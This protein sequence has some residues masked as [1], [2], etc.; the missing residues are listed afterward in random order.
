MKKVKYKFLIFILFLSPYVQAIDAV[1]KYAID[2]SVIESPNC[3]Q[4]KHIIQDDLKMD[5]K[6]KDCLCKSHCGSLNNNFII[7][8]PN[9]SA[10]LLRNNTP[11]L[12]FNIEIPFQESHPPFRPPII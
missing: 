7:V 4:T 5:C 6:C 9:K 10:T 1:G 12:L 3:H 8:N 11:V 2:H